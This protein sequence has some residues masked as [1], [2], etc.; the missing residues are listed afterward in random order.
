MLT[1][2]PYSKKMQKRWR[3]RWSAYFTSTRAEAD[4]ARQYRIFKDAQAA[5]LEFLDA[6]I[7]ATMCRVSNPGR[8][9]M[10]F[11]DTDIAAK[12]YSDTRVKVTL[13][14]QGEAPEILEKFHKVWNSCVQSRARTEA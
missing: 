6:E 9:Y 8:E 14:L 5:R 11:G 1:K 4:Q 13:T 7:A 2:K 3:E 12:V 10:R